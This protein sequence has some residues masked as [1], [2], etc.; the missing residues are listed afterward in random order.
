MQLVQLWILQALVKFVGDK[1]RRVT[2]D[3]INAFCH[4]G[5]KFFLFARLN[6]DTCEFVNHEPSP[7]ER[8]ECTNYQLFTV[9][10]QVGSRPAFGLPQ[11][12]G[13]TDYV[14]WANNTHY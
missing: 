13:V 14:C 5:L 12:S 11:P 3:F 6:M 8:V 4:S 1:A 10:F 7:I 2:N 9:E